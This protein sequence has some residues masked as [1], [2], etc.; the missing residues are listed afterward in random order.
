MITV[1]V[2]GLEFTFPEGWLASKYD[3]WSHYRSHRD[4]FDRMNVGVKA[5]DV[6]AVEPGECCWLVE[7]KDY[8]LH[9][10][11]KAIDI[12]AEFAQK[13]RDTL[14]GLVASQFLAND[15]QERDSARRALRATRLRVV[16]HLE[17]RAKPSKLFPITIDPADVRNKLKKL[18]KAIDPQ[19]RVVAMAAMRGLPWVVT[20]RTEP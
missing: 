19:P 7:V 6:L 12:A 5:V 17:Q 11:T 16:L 14:A 15:A 1:T 10:R 4:Q 3:D 8:R 2:E 9:Q 18:L 20:P 13:V